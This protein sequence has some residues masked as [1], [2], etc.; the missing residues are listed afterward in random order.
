MTDRIESSREEVYYPSSDVLANAYIKDWDELARRADDDFIAF[1]EG[2]AK[3]L[4][5]WHKPWTKVLDDSNQPFFKWFV[6]AK[7]N[8]VY[9][10]ID[11]H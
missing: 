10:A 4:I 5:D 3:E 7:T 9:N 8:I 11:R 2:C 1:W 6:D